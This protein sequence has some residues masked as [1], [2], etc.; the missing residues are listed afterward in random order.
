MPNVKI[1]QHSKSSSYQMQAVLSCE[2][3]GNIHFLKPNNKGEI[4]LLGL[5]LTGCGKDYGPYKNEEVSI[6]E[7]E[8]KVPVSTR[9]LLSTADHYTGHANG[10]TSIAEIEHYLTGN[11]ETKTS[12]LREDIT[13]LKNQILHEVQGQI[14]N[15]L[16][17]NY[18]LDQRIFSW[19]TQFDI[20]SGGRNYGT[21][22]QKLFSLTPTFQYKNPQG[23]VV[24]TG[25]TSLFTWGTEIVFSDAQGK[26][27]GSIKEKLFYSFTNI[28]SLYEIY[29]AQGKKIA[30]SKKVQFF[31]TQL[32]LSDT[33]GNVQ[34]IA[35]RPAI[36][37]LGDTW[38]VNSLNNSKIDPRMLVMFGPF[39][40]WSDDYH[41]SSNDDSFSDD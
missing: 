28:T 30:N 18:K 3:K 33:A 15:E 27:I 17:A 21:V 32:T 5:L 29:D 41:S 22:E 24:A 35:K 7:I 38:D 19:G 34:A 40:T 14:E 25:K 20:T 39:K 8:N 23:Q 36:N 12:F 31:S 2:L 4:M 9:E 10:Q 13:S 37:W 1:H 6:T 26:K 16:P 11:P